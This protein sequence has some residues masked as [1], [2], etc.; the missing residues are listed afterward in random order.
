MS[1]F[2]ARASG[3]ISISKI[4]IGKPMVVQAFGICNRISN[5][6]HSSKYSFRMTHIHNT[7][8]VT[9]NRSGTQKKINLIVV[10]AISL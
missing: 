3:L 10:I 5:K 6:V 2:L 1:I 4:S 8:N 7:G 9:F